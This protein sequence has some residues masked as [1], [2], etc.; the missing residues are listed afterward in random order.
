MAKLE[1]DYAEFLLGALDVSRMPHLKAMPRADS[2]LCCGKAFEQHVDRKCLYSST[3]YVEEP[4]IAFMT[5]FSAW[6]NGQKIEECL[7]RIVYELTKK[8]T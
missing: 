7:A 1:I 3:D 4:E 8:T 2:C 5:R 6:A